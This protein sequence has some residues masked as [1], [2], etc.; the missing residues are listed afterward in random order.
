VYVGLWAGGSSAH[1]N[2]YTPT[3][4]PVSNTD[5]SGSLWGIEEVC[6]LAVDSQ[7]GETSVYTDKYPAG[8][9]MK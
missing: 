5:Y 2:E 8:P 9:V 7:G 4:A 6:N 3:G 1:V